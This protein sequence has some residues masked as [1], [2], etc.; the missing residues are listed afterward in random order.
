MLLMMGANLVG[1]VIGVDGMRYFLSEILGSWQG[2][3]SSSVLHFQF[4]LPFTPRSRPSVSPRGQRLSIHCR[5]SDVRISVC[6]RC[7]STLSTLIDI[8]IY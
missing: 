5:S 6:H 8:C 1:F 3:F 2:S 4:G 7:R